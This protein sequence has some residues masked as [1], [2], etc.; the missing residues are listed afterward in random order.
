MS[1]LGFGRSPPKDVL[2]A[3]GLLIDWGW[4]CDDIPISLSLSLYFIFP[5]DPKRGCMYCVPEMF[6][7]AFDGSGGIS[8]NQ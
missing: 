8:L 2:W 1:F 7:L 3:A 6:A 5:Y 4:K